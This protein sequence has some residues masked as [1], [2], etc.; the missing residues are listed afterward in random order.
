[1]VVGF[2]QWPCTVSFHLAAGQRCISETC[3]S[4]AYIYQYAYTCLHVHITIAKKSSKYSNSCVLRHACLFTASATVSLLLCH[5]THIPVAWWVEQI[6]VCF[7][8]SITTRIM[9]TW[10]WANIEDSVWSFPFKTRS[11][12]AAT[13]PSVYDNIAGVKYLNFCQIDWQILKI[14]PIH[15]RNTLT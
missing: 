6:E 5:A 9:S 11:H 4:I 13:R 10:L 15:T 7:R 3:L 14:K 1:M 12:N 2:P 8:P